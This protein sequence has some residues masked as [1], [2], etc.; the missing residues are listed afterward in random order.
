MAKRLRGEVKG[1]PLSEAEHNLL[2]Q[3]AIEGSRKDAVRV[4]GSGG[5]GHHLM[6][7]IFAKLGVEDLVSAFWAM[8]WLRPLAYGVNPAEIR[9]E[10]L[11]E[12]DEH[13][14]RDFWARMA[15]K[16]RERECNE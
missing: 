14:E 4:T 10:Q 16:T 7:S 13:I 5:N 12:S 11:A 9:H 3:R 6:A 1:A 2:Y 8:G 15:A